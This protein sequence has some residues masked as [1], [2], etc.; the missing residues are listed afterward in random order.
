MIEFPFISETGENSRASSII[1][2]VKLHLSDEDPL[3]ELKDPL[4][5]TEEDKIVETEPVV[6]PVIKIEPAAT[7]IL[8]TNFC[9]DMLAMR[10]KAFTSVGR[11]YVCMPCDYRYSSMPALRRHMAIH[12]NWKRFRCMRCD[13]MCFDKREAIVH[14]QTIHHATLDIIKKFVVRM[15]ETEA[16][17]YSSKIFLPLNTTP[18]EI[19]TLDDSDEESGKNL[20]DETPEENK[21]EN[22]EENEFSRNLIMEMIIGVSE[23]SPPINPTVKEKCPM[24]TPPT[25]DLDETPPSAETSPT[26]TPNVSDLSRVSPF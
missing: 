20:T 12:F 19:I 21:D 22:P 23:P 4:A 2:S 24:N 26:N 9:S 15:S 16:D 18:Q 14:A 13:F 6:E 10:M 1:E 5:Y 7:K 8:P 25:S 11:K 17:S 3:E